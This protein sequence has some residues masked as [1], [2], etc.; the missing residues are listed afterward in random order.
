M[1]GCGEG[2]VQVWTW[3]RFASGRGPDQGLKGKSQI[4]STTEIG[5]VPFPR[6]N[7]AGQRRGFLSGGRLPVGWVGRFVFPSV[8][9][10]AFSGTGPSR[11]SKLIAVAS[12]GD[13]R[14]RMR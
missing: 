11:R 4:K 2:C 13:L 5:P 3:C 9:A 8:T 7:G 6:G 12:G 1:L 10:V 14:L